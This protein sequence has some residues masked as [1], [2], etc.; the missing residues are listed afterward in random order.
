MFQKTSLSFL[1]FPLLV[2]LFPLTAAAQP[3]YKQTNLVSDV[4]GLAQHTDPDLVNP[5]GLTR[6]AT[7]PLRTS[8]SSATIYWL[9][10]SVVARSPRSIPPPESS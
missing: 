8:A 5:W 9:E 10:I 2:V 7:S 1:A 6:S 4:P 3:H